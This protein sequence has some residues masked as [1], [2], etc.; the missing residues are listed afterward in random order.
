MTEMF[1]D[2]AVTPAGGVTPPLILSLVKTIDRESRVVYASQRNDMWVFQRLPGEQFQ[3]FS[4]T[5]CGEPIS[6]AMTATQSVTLDYVPAGDSS[7]AVSFR[8]WWAKQI[9]S[10]RPNQ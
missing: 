5:Q 3:L 6:D 1:A 10:P 9:S 7:T 8:A 2:E 4:C